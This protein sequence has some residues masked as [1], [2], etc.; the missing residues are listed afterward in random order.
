MDKSRLGELS[1]VPG[2]GD[3]FPSMEKVETDGM[4]SVGSFQHQTPGVWRHLQPVSASFTLWS[5]EPWPLSE[6]K[7]SLGLDFENLLIQPCL[8]GWQTPTLPGHKKNSLMT[9]Q[10][11]PCSL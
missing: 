2:M 11:S 3:L 9:A 5:R 10:D 6:T 1:L 4:I 7:A 8:P